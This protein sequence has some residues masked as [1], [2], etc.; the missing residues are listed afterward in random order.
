MQYSKIT[1]EIYDELTKYDIKFSDEY[2]SIVFFAKFDGVYIS[3]SDDEKFGYD[4]FEF[5]FRKL[6]NYSFDLIDEILEGKRNIYKKN[7]IF[8]ITCLYKCNLFQI[9]NFITK[10]QFEMLLKIHPAIVRR[11]VNDFFK[12]YRIDDKQSFD[13]RREMNLLFNGKGANVKNKYLKKYLSLTSFWEKMGLNY[14]DIQSLPFDEYYMYSLC[15]NV[16][17][18]IRAQKL[19]AK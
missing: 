14:Y 2:F 5:V 6:S 13:I 12:P 19:K 3:I 7:M 17:N 18:E 11:L 1:N 10:D 15:I 9:D 16:E 4:K 8:L